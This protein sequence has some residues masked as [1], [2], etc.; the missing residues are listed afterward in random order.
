MLFKSHSHSK[1]CLQYWC[2]SHG[3]C[4][5][6][7]S[8]YCLKLRFINNFSDDLPKNYFWKKYSIWKTSTFLIDKLI[9]PEL[10]PK[11]GTRLIS[12]SIQLCALLSHRP[13][14]LHHKQGVIQLAVTK[15]TTTKKPQH[16][17]HCHVKALSH[18]FL[19]VP[20]CCPHIKSNFILY[21]RPAFVAM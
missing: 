2:L 11:V 15:T 6:G 7:E 17:R 9:I 14:I 18:S 3:I 10:S 20:S 12:W 4:S 5:H 16:L 21:T 1:V 19:N 13:S 8:F